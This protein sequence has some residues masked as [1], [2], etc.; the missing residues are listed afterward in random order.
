MQS[1]AT[2]LLLALLLTL[3]ASAA[4][5]YSDDVREAAI[6]R[7]FDGETAVEIC[8]AMQMIQADTVL[9]LVHVRLQHASR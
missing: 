7:Y 6:C 9:N 5:T 1:S 3:L 8:G 4:A 2:M